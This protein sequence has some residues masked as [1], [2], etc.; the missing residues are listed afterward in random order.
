MPTISILKSKR[1]LFFLFFISIRFCQGQGN[2]VENYFI[3]NKLDKDSKVA[4]VLLEKYDC[5]DCLKGMNYI[6]DDLK[7]KGYKI[8]YLISNTRKKFLNENFKLFTGLD[9]EDRL[10]SNDTGLYNYLNVFHNQLIVKYN[11][12]H[13]PEYK[14]CKNYFDD[15]TDTVTIDESKKEFKASFQ[16]KLND[17]SYIM[18]DYFY[19]KEIYLLSINNG[20]RYDF[21]PKNIDSIVIDAYSQNLS[22]EK[23]RIIL[24]EFKDLK[25]K[26]TYQY[27]KPSDFLLNDS[28][29]IFLYTWDKLRFFNDSN[30]I[31]RN[32]NLIVFTDHDLNIKKYLTI[33]NNS[34]VGDYYIDVY[35]NNV[36]YDGNSFIFKLSWLQNEET[37][38]K[39]PYILGKYLIKGNELA[40]SE[41]YRNT[42]EPKIVQKIGAEYNLDEVAFLI[43]GNDSFYTL[44]SYPFLYKFGNPEFIFEI[45]NKSDFKG[46]SSKM[47]LEENRVAKFRVSE[48]KVIKSNIY[49]SV[50]EKNEKKIFVYNK[51]FKL[52]KTIKI[53]EPAAYI[54][55]FNENEIRF[56]RQD[57]ERTILYMVYY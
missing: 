8:Q 7:V 14:F 39:P 15:S 47:D 32:D 17:T 12:V 37:L 33:Q 35:F 25:K 54:F 34:I 10:I 9:P 57:E 26:E 28:E 56:I 23:S 24:D 29:Y 27:L 52:L 2:P 16:Y 36:L 3:N 1:F 11:G 49:I 18:L 20:E 6:E 22:K 41:F 4:F 45:P 5:L 13:N 50:F 38:P 44:S 53:N 31:S 48:M 30:L 42:E 19:G 40:F 55:D 51:D 46:F 21:T 43:I